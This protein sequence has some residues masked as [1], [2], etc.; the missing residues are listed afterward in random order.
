MNTELVFRY[1]ETGDLQVL[2][3]PYQENTGLEMV[4]LLPRKP[5]GLSALERDIASDRLDGW[6]SRMD[7]ALVRVALPRF[8]LQRGEALAAPLA[9]MGM[10][11]AFM[12]K[13]D[14]TGIARERPLV[15][16]E[17]YHK[18][19]LTVDEHGTEAAAGTSAVGSLGAVSVPPTRAVFTADHPFMFFIRDRHSGAILFMG[20]VM[21]PS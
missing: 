18:A 15:L 2:A 16:A 11:D 6:L 5:Q 19:D 9:S 14:F 20:R 13:A 10:S 17:V 8:R 4:L 1:C 3:L 12:V 7:N 21:D